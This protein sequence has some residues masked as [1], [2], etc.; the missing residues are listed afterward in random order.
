M[1]FYKIVKPN[2]KKYINIFVLSTILRLQ[3]NTSLNKLVMEIYIG[4]TQIQLPSE[5]VDTKIYE[6]TKHFKFGW[7][8]LYQAANLC[9]NRMN[10]F[11][12]YLTKST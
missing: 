2:K 10:V 9:S 3:K 12:L 11:S 5:N 7:T 4:Y 1:R 6:V 8:I